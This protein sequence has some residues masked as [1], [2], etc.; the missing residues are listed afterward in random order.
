MQAVGAMDILT[1]NCCFEGQSPNVLNQ[2][3]VSVLV[4]NTI[5]VNLNCIASG[6][7]NANGAFK[8]MQ[9]DMLL[10]CMLKVEVSH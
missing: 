7:I 1:Y 3:N 5:F 10:T 9:M 6:R 2:L 8:D 4:L